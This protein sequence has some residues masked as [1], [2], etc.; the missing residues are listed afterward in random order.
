MGWALRGLFVIGATRDPVRIRDG[1]AANTRALADLMMKK[2]VLV[3]LAAAQLLLVGGCNPKP[4][5]GASAPPL[6]IS[7]QGSNDDPALVKRREA[8]QQFLGKATGRPVKLYEASDYNGVIQALASGQVDIATL[9]GG[10]YA[11]ADA[12][13]GEKIAPILTVRRADGGTGYYSA[14]MV[15]A[16]SPFRSLADLKGKRLGYVDFNSTSGYLYPRAQMREA[17]IDPDTYFSNTTF[18]GG[19]TQAIMALAN[20]QFD[21]TFVQVAG[22]D[23]V[24]GFSTGAVYTMAK[25]GLVDLKA[26]RTLWVIGPIPDTSIV[27]RTDR[28]QAD[29]DLVRGAMASLPYDEP[30]IWSE[31]GQPEG[32]TF[33]AI[34]RRHYGEVIRLRNADIALRRK[35]GAEE[36]A[37]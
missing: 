11:N 36:G 29:I 15:R 14:L 7:M 5:S 37:R 17:G 33:T 34:D 10:S 31:I 13:V 4:E 35:G 26:F 6:R 24:H 18:A 9:A 22:G 23:P 32:S 8:Y 16:D 2:T 20:G 27:V 28:S 3:L 21:A 25:R 19:H 1:V 12:Q 30:E